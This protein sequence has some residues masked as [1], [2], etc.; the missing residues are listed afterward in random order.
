MP[1]LNKELKSVFGHI[2][3]RKKLILIGTI[4]LL[5]LLLYSRLFIIIIFIFLGGISKIYHR[6]FRSALG[7]DLV[8]FTTVMTALVYGRALAL[9]VAWAGL[10]IAEMLGSRFSYTSMVTLIG[11]TTIVFLAKFF[12]A[13]PLVAAAILLTLI[14]EIIMAILYYFVIGSSLYRIYLF[15]SSHLAFNL[16][17]IFSFAVKIKEIMI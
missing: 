6:F 7:I 9:V 2:M 5:L 3:K 16:F 13:L 8:F 10:I 11:L 17:M 1:D 15:L 12:A 14:F 4:S